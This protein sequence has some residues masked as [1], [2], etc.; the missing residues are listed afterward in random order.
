MCGRFAQVIKHDDLVKL[1]KE[2]KANISADQ[3]EISYNVAPTQTVMAIVSKGFLR[4]DGYFRWGLV[5]SWM[6]ELPKTPLIN[7]RSESI[8]EKPSFKASFIRR[9][10]II[11]INGFYEWQN[12]GKIPYFIY[13][14]DGS[15]LYLAGI[16]DVWEGAD[17]SFLP[18]IGIITTEAD[19]NMQKIHHRM[20]VAVTQ[21]FIDPWMDQSLQDIKEL[22]RLLCSLPTPQLAYH[23]VSP[24]VNK[25]A[26]N[27]ESLM[28]KYQAR[29]ELQF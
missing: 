3:I 5:P 19:D 12:P 4:Y 14:A 29:E 27:Y 7:I 23:R 20:P 17:G 6:K 16:F 18:S 24:E 15:L 11:P 21:D 26:N 1:S 8:H 2:L 13:P 25:V 28:E 9:R 10:A 22:R